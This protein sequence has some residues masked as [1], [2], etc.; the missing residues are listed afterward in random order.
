MIIYLE[1]QDYITHEIIERVYKT[2]T[3]WGT[4]GLAFELEN[5][6]FLQTK[7]LKKGDAQNEQLRERYKKGE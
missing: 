3:K 5:G 4:D 1:N 2:Q 6:D 7:V